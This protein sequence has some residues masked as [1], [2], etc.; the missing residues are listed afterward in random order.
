MHTKCAHCNRV[1]LEVV[2]EKF[3][4]KK[5]KKETEN[6]TIRFPVELI[7]EIEEFLVG[8]DETFSSFVIQ[9]CKYALDNRDKE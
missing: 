2:M 9:A 7:S 4:L 1:I 5:K 8:T 3:V 6:K